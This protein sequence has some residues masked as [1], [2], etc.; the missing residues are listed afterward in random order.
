MHG[1]VFMD[2]S[3]Y[4]GV[5]CRRCNRIALVEVTS[6]PRI[7]QWFVP[8]IPPFEVQCEK[9]GTSL[10]YRSR[11]VIVFEAPTLENLDTHPAFRN[12]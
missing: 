6:G 1:E 2:A 7:S 9:C 3:V 10:T 8:R 12:V 11:H 4:F 5:R